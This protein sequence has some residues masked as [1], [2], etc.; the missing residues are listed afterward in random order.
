MYRE[1][2]KLWPFQKAFLAT[3]VD[4]KTGEIKLMKLSKQTGK[5]LMKNM[6]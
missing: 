4:A 1:L 3:V 6:L 5:Q 2:T